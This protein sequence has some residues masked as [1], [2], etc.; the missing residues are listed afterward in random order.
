M[1][2][3]NIGSRLQDTKLIKLKLNILLHKFVTYPETIIFNMQQRCKDESLSDV[4]CMEKNRT[5]R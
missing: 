4:K 3:K 5:L 1:H 2:F